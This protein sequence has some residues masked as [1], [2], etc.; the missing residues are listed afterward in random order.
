MRLA[1]GLLAVMSIGALSQALAT[2]PQQPSSTA[3]QP[4]QASSPSQAAAT[5]ATQQAGG[6]PVAAAPGVAT[7]AAANADKPAVA[8]GKL[9][10]EL[11]K[12]AHAM[13]YKIKH[14]GED[15]YF[16]R[17]EVKMGSRFE[18]EVCETPE[19][20]DLAARQT[21]D[22]VEKTQRIGMPPFN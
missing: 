20:L 10:P 3:A 15:V 2:E 22:M 19:K 5:P 7:T 21:R 16:C 11:V 4:A 9:D 13:G 18:T 1:I 8:K 6:K 14:R 12:K 17:N